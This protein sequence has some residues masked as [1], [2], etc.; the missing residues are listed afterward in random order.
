MSGLGE[1]LNNASKNISSSID[2][3]KSFSPAL[4]VEDIF[5]SLTKEI[6]E[7]QDRLQHCEKINSSFKDT[8]AHA[9]DGIRALFRHI[10][11]LD[12]LTKATESRLKDTEKEIRRKGV[13]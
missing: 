2:S 7:L 5:K 1:I 8:L 9:E 12:R 3:Y 6:I 13:I 11:R 10:E 4:T